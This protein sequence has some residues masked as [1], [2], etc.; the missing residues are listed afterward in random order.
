MLSV[1]GIF[2]I[3]QC[4]NRLKMRFQFLTIKMI[5]FK[6]REKITFHSYFRL[7][8]FLPSKDDEGS[9]VVY[10]SKL[11]VWMFVF[12]SPLQVNKKFIQGTNR[13]TIYL[14]VTV[15]S[16]ALL[17]TSLFGLLRNLINHKTLS[18]DQR[19]L[20]DLPSS[21]GEATPVPGRQRRWVAKGKTNAEFL[22]RED[23][24][25]FWPFLHKFENMGCC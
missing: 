23:H 5:K 12:M 19:W 6:D 8:F 24:L 22:K 1:G 7:Y 20:Q 3:R 25:K 17:L 11:R 4:G 14:I 9:F 21:H 15:L 18:Y 2:S 10:H 13:G 16:C